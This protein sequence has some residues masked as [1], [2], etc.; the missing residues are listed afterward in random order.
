MH[1]D[2]FKMHQKCT[3]KKIL[4][5]C[6]LNAVQCIVLNKWEFGAYVV[7][8]TCFPQNKKSKVANQVWP[9]LSCNFFLKWHEKGKI[10]VLGKPTHMPLH[11]L[12]CVWLLTLAGNKKLPPSSG[13]HRKGS[14]I[15][16]NVRL[17]WPKTKFLAT[18]WQ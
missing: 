10:Y 14:Y 13:Q 8:S 15:W 12:L 6:I 4:F 18:Y 7:Y 5:C 17:T 3:V 16:G 11:I 1:C 9:Q 2:A